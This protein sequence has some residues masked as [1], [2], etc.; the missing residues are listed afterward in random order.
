MKNGNVTVLA[1][2]ITLVASIAFA[3]GG[4]TARVGRG[5]VFGCGQNPDGNS[6]PRKHHQVL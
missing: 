5:F 1:I 3:G 2:G 4:P 6:C